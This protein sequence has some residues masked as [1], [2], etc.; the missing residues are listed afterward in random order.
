MSFFENE[1]GTR[2]FKG[3]KLRDLKHNQTEYTE[4]KNTV[5]KT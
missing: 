3:Q 4:K 2:D 5:Y 1:L